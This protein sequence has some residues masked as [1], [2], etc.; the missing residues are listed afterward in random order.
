M[1]KCPH[2]LVLREVEVVHDQVEELTKPEQELH[3][4]QQL[5]HCEGSKQGW[6]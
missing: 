2:W 4:L 6:Q 5:L 3:L 1:E